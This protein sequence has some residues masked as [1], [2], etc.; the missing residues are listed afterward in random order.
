[1]VKFLYIYKKKGIHLSYQ[2]LKYITMTIHLITFA[3][4][5]QKQS[6]PRN[7]HEA[8]L[9]EIEKY[10]TI[11]F[12]DGQDINKLSDDDFKILFIATGGV[13]RMVIQHFE[14]LPRPSFP[15]PPSNQA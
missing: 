1:M 14:Q 10:Y 7:T 2:N 5:L 3:A 11:K 15:Q 13:E 6:S 8:I 9:S 12:V 4:P